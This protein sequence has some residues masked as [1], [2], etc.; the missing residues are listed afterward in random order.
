MVKVAALTATLIISGCAS[1]PNTNVASYQL[2]SPDQ[3]LAVELRLS[4]EQQLEYRVVADDQPVMA[5][6]P[7]GLVAQSGQW[8]EQLSVMKV[9]PV[10]AVSDQ[11]QL[12]T[13]KQTNVDYQANRLVLTLANPA[14]QQLQVNMQLAN[15]GLAFRYQLA[16]DNP[17]VYTIERELTA[18]DLLPETRSWL[19]PKALARS[20]WADTNPS[21]EEDYL[22]DVDA[23]VAQ[24]SANGWVYPALFRHNDQWLLISEAGIRSHYPATNLS[25]DGR[26][27]F[28]LRFPDP[29]ESVA[30][31]FD[32]P[33]L[34]AQQ[35]T[36]WR[37]IAVGSLDTIMASTLATDVAPAHQ[38]SDTD[39]IEPGVAAW[40]WGLL[41]DES[42]NADTQRQFI[43]YA[44]D[45][46]W[47]Y[48]LVDVDWHTRIGEQKLK[49]LIAHAAERDVRLWLWYN[50]SGDWNTTEYG[51]KSQLIARQQRRAQFAWLQQLGVAGVKIDF[52]P[53]DGASVM[54]Y[55][56]ALLS[57]AAEFDL[58]VNF[59]GTTLPRG[60]QRA[61]PNLM[62]SEAVKGFEMIT[63]F[64]PVADNEA[65]HATVLPF[66]R[67][68]F[69]PMD[70]TP[71]TL[72][73]IPN[74]ERKTSNA[75]QLAL[76]VIFTSGVQHLVATPEQMA[77]M[78]EFVKSY[79]R[80]LPGRW[81]QSQLLEGY[82]GKYIS[83]AR[84]SE[85]A[86]YIAGINALSE[87]KSFELNLAQFNPASA[88]LIQQGEQ[89]HDLTAS[90]LSGAS[91]VINVAPASGFVVIL[92]S[93]NS[94]DCKAN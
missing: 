50:S 4:P 73:D 53:G 66:T 87:Y 40:S 72:G 77:A 52:F 22:V 65:V 29:R 34:S 33:L 93:E 74:I 68:V 94:N 69:D 17:H 49:Q 16:A 76:P 59:H 84:T 23:K 51:P 21:Y 92:K 57:D 64:Q 18:L 31:A 13:G 44:A 78:P 25:S 47:P 90:Q 14:G 11:Y 37:I 36:P 54:A 86:S 41:K 75:F 30:P 8:Q 82:P 88:T 63:F 32:T 89:F 9:S 39:F 35:P 38:F 85:C 46:N 6:S 56:Q 7:L 19:Q 26:G 3:R 91:A 80:D 27:R 61:Y 81:Q 43:D 24:T 83:I 12:W 67:N 58:M 1:G 70:F 5:Y 55:Y 10:S 71:M 15:D 2:S 79:L 42:V 45:M 28:Q 20:G 60:L 62:T 48:V